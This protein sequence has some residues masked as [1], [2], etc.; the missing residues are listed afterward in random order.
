MMLK[1]LGYQCIALWALGFISLLLLLGN[2]F[3]L[4][5]RCAKSN[6]LTGFIY[7]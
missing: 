1:G 5:E 2:Y 6:I 4:P 3:H 7:K